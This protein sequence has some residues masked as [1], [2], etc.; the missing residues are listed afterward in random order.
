MLH[1]LTTTPTLLALNILTPEQHNAARVRLED[2]VRYEL[3]PQALYVV[4]AW[5]LPSQLLRETPAALVSGTG[6]WDGFSA[7]DNRGEVFWCRWEGFGEERLE[8]EAPSCQI[9]M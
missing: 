2:L 4:D 3:G 5:G 8:G 7:G 6:G 9:Q 1:T